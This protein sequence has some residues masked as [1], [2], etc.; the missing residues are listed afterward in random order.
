MRRAQTYYKGEYKREQERLKR[1]NK[2][3][4]WKAVITWIC[5]LAAVYFVVGAV[6]HTLNWLTN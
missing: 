3:M 6:W 4:R 2:E 5:L 1:V